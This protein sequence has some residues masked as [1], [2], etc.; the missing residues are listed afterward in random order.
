MVRAST[1]Y[2][3]LIAE[4]RTKMTTAAPAIFELRQQ[5]FAEGNDSGQVAAAES[6][7]LH[8]STA[9]TLNALAE[10]LCQLRAVEQF[11]VLNREAVR[12]IIKKFDKKTDRSAKHD[13]VM[14]EMKKRA[15]FESPLYGPTEA[16]YASIKMMF[17]S[18]G[19]AV[20]TFLTEKID[21]IDRFDPY[22]ISQ[23]T[24]D[25]GSDDGKDDSKA[26]QKEADAAKQTGWKQYLTARYILA[27]L[28]IVSGIYGMVLGLSV[29][30]NPI[31]TLVYL[32]IPVAFV[33]A[34]ANGANDIA[35]SMG[36]SVGAK[37]LTLRQ[38]LISGAVLEF[39]GAMTMGQFVSKTI[40]KGVLKTEEFEQSSG[41]FALAMFSVLVAAAITTMIATVYGYPISATHSIIGGLISVGLAAKGR[42]AVDISG[43]TKTCIAW[44]ASPLLGM[45]VAAIFYLIITKQVLQAVDPGAAS[46]KAQY[47]FV[48]LTVAVAASFI[49]MKGPEQVQVR[50]YGAAVGVALSIGLGCT[51]IFYFYKRYQAAQ[52]PAAPAAGVELEARGASADN[53]SSPALGEQAAD[54]STTAT[55]EAVSDELSTLS[56]RTQSYLAANN[57]G[58]VEPDEGVDVAG[59]TTRFRLPSIGLSPE[60]SNGHSRSPTPTNMTDAYEGDTNDSDDADGM[61]KK[62][63]GDASDNGT[64]LD[65]EGMAKAQA[66][67]AAEQPFVPLLVLSAL[68]VAF[69][70][71][72]NDVGNAVGP[73][74][75]VWEVFQDE[76]AVSGK[77]DTATWI[78][79]IGA[80][81]FVAGIMLLGSRTIETV[82]TKITIL[83]PSKS[84]STQMGAAVAVL[85]SS[86]FGMPV[87][88]S[89]CLVGAVVGVGV[90]QK[91][92]QGGGKINGSALGKIL[93]GWLVTIPLAMVF[94][95]IVFTAASSTYD[96]ETGN[97]SHWSKVN[98]STN[99]SGSGSGSGLFGK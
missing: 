17:I 88:T 24:P 14:D 84:F 29:K 85:A 93:L 9:P 8:P 65:A 63:K 44:V 32:G 97:C 77:P 75:V 61:G 36:T 66:Q 87:S 54:P 33:M 64:D 59:V 45:L 46:Q 48:T 98:C 74:G 70:H 80:V 13:E 28:L 38:A 69:A 79:A 42:A 81:G 51:I 16:Y 27:A 91:F 37:A 56:G 68:S 92:T 12:K 5:F 71:G 49:L 2:L 40:S 43:I 34:I 58:P 35:N 76:T 23:G 50:P 18:A 82:G 21:A 96:F 10:R 86:A 39:L 67:E 22:V 52:A 30:P 19:A 95:V 57:D 83:T 60:D 89:H 3:D 26:N 25:D 7:W 90:A 11:G 62:K 4:E 55:I 94:A 72:G 1:F 53:G 20:E 99:G 6:G 31:A 78:L 47:V 73:L 15:Y 41:L